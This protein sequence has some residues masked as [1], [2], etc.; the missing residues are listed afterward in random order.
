MTREPGFY[1]V[2]KRDEMIKRDHFLWVYKKSGRLYYQ[3]SNNHPK[4]LDDSH[5]YDLEQYSF[6]KKIGVNRKD[7]NFQGSTIT[8]NTSHGSF[9][10]E[11]RVRT[12]IELYRLIVVLLPGIGHSLMINNFIKKIKNMYEKPEVK[13]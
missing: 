3:E 9:A 10:F 11:F 5:E 8:I 6:V 7:L 2:H 13:K 12:L 4:P 1:I